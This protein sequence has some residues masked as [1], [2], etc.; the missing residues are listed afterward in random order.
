MLY[1]NNSF[2]VLKNSWKNVQSIKNNIKKS[3]INPKA[4]FLYQKIVKTTVN[5]VQ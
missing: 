2:K 5:R 4:Q 3:K 1:R